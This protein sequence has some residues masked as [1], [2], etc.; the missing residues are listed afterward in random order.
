MVVPPTTVKR[1]SFHSI[2]KYE[3]FMVQ[4]WTCFHRHSDRLQ[5]LTWGPPL[6]ISLPFCRDVRGV[7]GSPWID[8]RMMPL[9]VSLSCRCTPYRCKNS[10]GEN[11]ITSA[12]QN[13]YAE[14]RCRSEAI[15]I[16]WNNLI[17]NKKNSS[18]DWKYN[19]DQT[20]SC[21]RD[22]RPWNCSD[23]HSVMVLGGLNLRD[24]LTVGTP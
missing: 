22:W 6:N 24:V 16:I 23:F 15:K 5:P 19:S 11:W 12:H 17:W 7:T 18:S 4:N 21:S 3:H 20:Y 9:S 1:A 8:P 14:L 2:N 13:E 10:K